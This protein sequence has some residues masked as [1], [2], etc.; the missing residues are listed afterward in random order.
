VRI[1]NVEFQTLAER[2]RHNTHTHTIKKIMQ[3]KVELSEVKILTFGAE[4]KPQ[5]Q[6]R[7]WRAQH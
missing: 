3:A 2:E 1:Q 4:P 6:S 7:Q 5:E